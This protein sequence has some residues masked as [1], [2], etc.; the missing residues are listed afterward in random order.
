MIGVYK[1]EI[2]TIPS[3]IVVDAENENKALPVI[4]FFHG[5]TSA[6]EHNLPLAYLLAEEGYRVVLPDSKYHG[7]R[8]NEISEMRRQVSFW[9]IV[10]QNV[11][12]L[13]DIKDYL[14]STGLLLDNRFGIAGTS[15]GGITTSAALT[16]YPWIKTA[17]ILMGSPKITTYAKTLV[18]S[19]KKMG[20]LP[21]T[22]EEIS[23]L[24]DQLKQYD[25]SE[26]PEKL[27]QRPLMFWHGEDDPVVP[28]DHSYTFYEKVASEY[29]N[30]DNIFF[31]KEANRGHK[32]G[33][34]AI[35]ETAKW[36]TK[37]L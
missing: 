3:L 9:D 7:A 6:K 33:R 19:F 37:H 11:I 2:K 31:I 24:Y 8:E 26:Q 4:T 30:K 27:N 13:K 5:F 16:Q 36:F 12:E 25:L 17:V 32:V 15:M 28:F 10:M 14:D 22:D 21:V 1:E 34:F 18:N 20:N 35:L 23:H 29:T